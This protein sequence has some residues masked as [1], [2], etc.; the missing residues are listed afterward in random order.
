[1]DGEYVK[2]YAEWLEEIRNK[3]TE[4]I[5]RYRLDE[6]LVKNIC[7]EERIPNYIFRRSSPEREEILPD[8]S[9]RLSLTPL[10]KETITPEKIS[11][12]KEISD[13]AE[14]PQNKIIDYCLDKI[15]RLVVDN[16]IKFLIKGLTKDA[17]E[18]ESKTQRITISDIRKAVNWLKNN[19]FKLHGEPNILI[20]HPILIKKFRND[21][22]LLEEKHFPRS[23]YGEKLGHSFGWIN[24]LCVYGT[25]HVSSNTALIYDKNEACL[26]RAKIR[27]D[28]DNIESPRYLFVKEK[29]IAWLIDPNGLVKIT[30]KRK[31]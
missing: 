7:E 23:F 31:N 28:F 5:I 29:R 27:I 18:F 17:H 20:M 9:T 10:I 8:G 30:T 1:M 21:R 12:E 2:T 11:L 3:I 25:R 13:W 22:E 15:G 6:D 26:R 24:G 4:T 19:M 16:E 14:D